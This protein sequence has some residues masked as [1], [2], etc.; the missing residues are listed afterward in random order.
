MK[1]R[2]FAGLLWFYVTWYAW[3]FIASAFGVSE[4]LGPVLA[5]IVAVLV[6]GDPFGRIWNTNRARP[7][8]SDHSAAV[9]EPA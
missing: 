3:G 4:L 1:K 2:V 8:V 7:A 6:A 9:G 5:L